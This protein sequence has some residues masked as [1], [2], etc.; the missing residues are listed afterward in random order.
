MTIIITDTWI[1]FCITFGV[2][3]LATVIMSQ[4]SKYFYTNDGTVRSF[5]ILDL[6]LAANAV[7][8]VNLIKGIF[9]LPK[10]FIAKTV[11]K[12]LKGQL[13]VDFIFMPAAYGSIFL[14]C[15]KTSTKLITN[16]GQNIF[17]V[18]AWLQ[19]LAWLC[20]ILENCYLLGKVVPNPSQTPPAAYKVYQ[21][22]EILKWGISLTG[23]VCGIAAM[24]YFW[25]VG[26]FS[27]SSLIYLLVIIAEIVLIPL[28]GGLFSKKHVVAS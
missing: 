2:M 20:D 6:E 22:N 7:E 3:Q 14:V 16:G 12:A 4:Q 24:L 13:Y 23:A 15:M 8:I 18:L 25:V 28:L 26:N 17:A 10:P 21:L 27:A 1:W 5:S 11:T 9:L 19:A